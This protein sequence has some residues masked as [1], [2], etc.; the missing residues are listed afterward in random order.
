MQARENDKKPAVGFQTLP[1][2]S[3]PTTVPSPFPMFSSAASS[4]FPT[5]KVTAA[6]APRQTQASA[7][8]HLL[9]SPGSAPNYYFGNST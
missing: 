6:L 7:A 1:M 2:W 3:Q 4:G 5:N 8:H 9:S